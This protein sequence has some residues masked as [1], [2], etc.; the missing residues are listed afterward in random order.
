MA[1]TGKKFWSPTSRA[2][3]ALVLAAALLPAASAAA[4][5]EIGDSR[6]APLLTA[7]AVWQEVDQATGESER[8]LV[9][10]AAET[11][12]RWLNPRAGGLLPMRDARLQ[13]FL[14]G[15]EVRAGLRGHIRLALNHTEFPE[16]ES[17]LNFINLYYDYER[18]W[19]RAALGVG[20]GSLLLGEGWRDPF[21]FD[22]ETTESRLIY[23]LALRPV[24]WPGR[25]RLELGAGN[26]DDFEYH[27]AD[28]LGFR[29]APSLRLS[30]NADLSVQYERR[31]AAVFVDAPTLI[32]ASWQVTLTR[33]F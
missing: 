17:G 22:P 8:L 13:A 23:D 28:D 6:P 5:M 27:G 12:S 9:S 3:A 1:S 11:R 7:A 14:V 33:R 10:L 29:A 4:P 15:N 31:Y 19:L 26:L 24:L 25:L 30:D 21:K 18:S 32:R 20:Y 2:L 16:W